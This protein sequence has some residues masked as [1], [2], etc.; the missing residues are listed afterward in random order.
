MSFLPTTSYY[1]DLVQDE[2]T[3]LVLYQ[4]VV[5]RRLEDVLMEEFERSI[6]GKEFVKSLFDLRPVAGTVSVMYTL[7]APVD[8]ADIIE[9]ME[10]Y[11]GEGELIS[12]LFADGDGKLSGSKR[13]SVNLGCWRIVPITDNDKITEVMMSL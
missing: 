7:Q 3:T 11:F 1:H 10:L 4:N 12:K 9:E 5:K 8:V 6:H 2:Y 13:L